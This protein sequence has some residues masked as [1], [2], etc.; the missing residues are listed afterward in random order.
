MNPDSVSTQLWFVG[1]HSATAVTTH[2]PT[3]FLIFITFHSLTKK[4]LDTAPD[5]L[6]VI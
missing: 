6:G 5:E 4:F 1:T 3:W 2:N